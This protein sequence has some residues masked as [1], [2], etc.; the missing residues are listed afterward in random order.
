MDVLERGGHAFN[1]TPTVIDRDA[2]S[3][4]D[5]APETLERVV[6]LLRDS[7]EVC[8]RAG[9][10]RRLEIPDLLAPSTCAADQPGV[11]EHAEMLRDSLP[12]HLRE[13]VR[14]VA[15]ASRQAL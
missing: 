10:T 12:R 4:L 8:V 5:E 7:I 6:P 11:R 3:V 1:M 15:P 13:A 14:R 2:S 9:E